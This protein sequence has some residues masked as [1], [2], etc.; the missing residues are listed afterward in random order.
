MMMMG[1]FEESQL[2]GSQKILKESQQ[3]MSSIKHSPSFN[4]HNRWTTPDHAIVRAMTK[5]IVDENIY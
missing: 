2:T 5:R 3:Q 4:Q 1:I